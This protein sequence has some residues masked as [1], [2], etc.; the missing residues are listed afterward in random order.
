MKTA[1]ARDRMVKR[2]ADT[3]KKYPSFMLLP[4]VKADLKK[5]P[6]AAVEADTQ[7]AYIAALHKVCAESNPIGRHGS[8]VV[9]K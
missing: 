8:H 9:G 6:H 5:A 2:V 4:E 3:F 1:E 7:A